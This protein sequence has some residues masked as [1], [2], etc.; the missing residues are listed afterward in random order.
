MQFSFNGGEISPEMYGRVDTSK[1]QT[2]LATCLNFIVQTH[3]PVEFRN[4]FE[5]VAMG[6]NDAQNARLIPFIFSDEQAVVLCFSYPYMYVFANG[7]QVLGD[8][9]QPI[10]INIPWLSNDLAQ[11][12]Y[13]QSA[14]VVTITHPAY[15]PVTIKRLSATN[16]QLDVIT[17]DY[18]IAAPINLTAVATTAQTGNSVVHRY[19][20]TAVKDTSESMAS[21]QASVSNDLTLAG[22]YNTLAWDAVI[23]ATRYRVY[24]LRSGLYSFIG[25]TTSTTL[26]D[27]YIEANGALTP[28][29]IRNPFASWPTAVSYFGQRKVYGGGI[30]TPQTLNFS[31]TA[32]DNN[33]T[34]S[35]PMRDDDAIQ[36]RFA[37]RDGNAVKHLVPMGDLLVL[38]G[39]AVWRV[40]SDGALSSTSVTVKPQSFTGANDVTPIQAGGAC[41]F[42]S[43]QTGRIHE[44]SLSANQS[45]T[46]QTIELSIMCPHLFDGYD[47]IDMAMVRNPWPVVFMV[48]NDGVLIG[49]TYDAQ[50]GVYAFHQHT[51]Q[52]TFES[53][54]AIPEDNQN[55]LYAVVKR[56]TKKYVERLKLRKASTLKYENHMDCSIIYDGEATS[57]LSGLDYL[58]GFEVSVLADGALHPKVMVTGGILSLQQDASVIIVGLDYQGLI[59][60]LPLA[61][62]EINATKPKIPTHVNLR[63]LNSS[64]IFAGQKLEQMQEFKQ[65]SNEPYGTAPRLQ[66]G[67]IEI[68]VQGSYD[69]DISLYVEQ[70]NPLPLIIQAMAVK[71]AKGG[72]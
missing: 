7:A 61:G 58:E 59:K 57:Q 34:Y 51:T 40:S 32:T 42:A 8:D 23:G 2:G 47:I 37:A 45:S 13:A 46:Y 63:V 49:M 19:A 53:V 35:I 71:L 21:L 30:N 27:D 36:V 11:L 5:Y 69:T 39:G 52:G 17:T 12:R 4:G 55:V 24:K 72:Q 10:R 22:N 54:A 15:Q 62:N 65:R 44:L 3:G 18:G 16:W 66:T 33:F 64:S 56:G 68:P 43:G 50:Q 28:P 26:V 20:V 38:T 70:N 48:R 1:Y 6:L 29:L 25:E 14:D 9:N 41:I 67:I 60:S 31:R